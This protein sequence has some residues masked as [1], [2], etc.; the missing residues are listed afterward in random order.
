M[1]HRLSRNERTERECLLCQ[2][3]TLPVATGHLSAHQAQFTCYALR[4]Q[5]AI[6]VHNKGRLIIQRFTDRD[7]LILTTMLYLIICGIHGKLRRTISINQADAAVRVDCHLFTT[8]NEILHWKVIILNEYLTYLS[9][10]T[11]SRDAI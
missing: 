4:Q 6:F 7:I 9:T 1:I 8:H 11:A 10:I 5:I 3:F 2:V